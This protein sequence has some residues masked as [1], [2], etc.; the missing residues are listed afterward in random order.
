MSEIFLNT[1]ER[2][3]PTLRAGVLGDCE[4]IVVEKI[5]HLARAPFD[6]ALEGEHLE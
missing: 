1:V 6:V 3:E 5:E 2:L 4:K